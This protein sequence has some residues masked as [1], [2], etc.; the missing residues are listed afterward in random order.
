MATFTDDQLVA[1]TNQVI[2][3]ILAQVPAPA[4]APAAPKLKIAPPEKF[5]GDRKY[6]IYDFVSAV[7]RSLAHYGTTDQPSKIRFAASFL[8]GPPNEWFKASW[9]AFDPAARAN[10]TWTEFKTRLLAVF[11]DP[12]RRLRAAHDLRA[13]KQKTSASAYAAEFMSLALITKWDEQ[14]QIDQ[15]YDGLKDNVKLVIAQGVFPADLNSMVSEA[16]RIDG[17]LF[18]AQTRAKRFGSMG[19]PFHRPQAPRRDPNAMDVDAA[20]STPLSRLTPEER[21]RLRKAGRCF[22][23]RQTGHMARECPGNSSSSSSSSSSRPRGR[24]AATNFKFD[25]ETGKPN[26]DYV[27]PEAS[28]KSDF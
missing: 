6:S 27:A 7:E 13:L 22:R 10:F 4:A 23:C 14:A 8:E 1:F 18:E 15:F 9:D 16:V 3:Q 24:I 19:N 25:P 5:S 20:S 28:E 17:R 21:D 2:A 12:D 11:G 26:P